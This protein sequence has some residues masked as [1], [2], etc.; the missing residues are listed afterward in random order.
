MLTG[1]VEPV[2]QVNV[3][4]IRSSAV[5]IIE[6]SSV[7]GDDNLVVAATCGKNIPLLTGSTEGRLQVYTGAIPQP[8]AVH[9]GEGFP[10]L[11]VGDGIRSSV[12][13]G[14]FPL[15]ASGASWWL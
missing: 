11:D 13:T 12:S 15:L 8:V 6:H 7:I 10:T 5:G 9:G 2:L 3:A 4:A 1:N 14:E